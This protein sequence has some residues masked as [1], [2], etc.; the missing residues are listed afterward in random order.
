MPKVGISPER[1]PKLIKCRLSPK[2]VPEPKELAPRR[3][4]GTVQHVSG[5]SRRGRARPPCR[6]PPGRAPYHYNRPVQDLEFVRRV[7][8]HL[9]A[10]M[11]PLVTR[12]GAAFADQ[13]KYFKQTQFA[14]WL[15][16]EAARASLVYGTGFNRKS[17]TYDDLLCGVP[18]AA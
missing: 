7:R 9:P 14:P 12:Y 18:G 10:T 8:R 1:A 17:A 6:L 11:V 3:W 16:A 5:P 13:E 2:Q 4:A 15:L